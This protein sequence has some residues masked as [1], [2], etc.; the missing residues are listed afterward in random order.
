MSDTKDDTADIQVIAEVEIVENTPPASPIQILSQ[1]NGVPP[2]QL[3][4]PSDD[5]EES[6]PAA[7]KRTLSC[8]ETPRKPR[9][10]SKLV[11][12]CMCYPALTEH[13]WNKGFAHVFDSQ[14]EHFE[15][16]D[17]KP[18]VRRSDIL[19][20]AEFKIGV[21]L[22]VKIVLLRAD[23]KV[24]GKRV[25][26]VIEDTINHVI[27]YARDFL[28]YDF[29]QICDTL[30]AHQSESGADLR[31]PNNMEIDGP[32]PLTLSYINN[33]VGACIVFSSTY[34]GFPSD[35]IH[36]SSFTWVEMKNI[37]HILSA[38]SEYYLDLCLQGRAYQDIPWKRHV[39]LFSSD[40][41]SDSDSCPKKKVV[42]KTCDCKS[43]EEKK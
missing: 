18:R 24:A 35:K 6:T 31:F 25:L 22:K 7:P 1:D 38:V 4:L 2:G 43:K 36:I 20:Q 5:D 28:K 40:E 9:G 29:T 37:H 27:M 11:R 13:E 17:D 42:C 19:M 21:N 30:A 34:N 23:N 14:F 41:D 16:Q 15:F 10:F 26:L 39:P 12:K 8:P 3:D 33:S 32:I